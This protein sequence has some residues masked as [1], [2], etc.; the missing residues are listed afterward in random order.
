[1]QK[2]LLLWFLANTQQIVVFNKSLQLL[3]ARQYGEFVLPDAA[4]GQNPGTPRERGQKT[5]P[6]QGGHGAL[7]T[8]RVQILLSITHVAVQI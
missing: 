7:F 2:S 5:V 3:M 6:V 1:M 8:V 4:A